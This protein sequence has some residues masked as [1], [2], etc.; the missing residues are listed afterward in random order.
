MLLYCGH[1]VAY[2]LFT[3]I[4]CRSEQYTAVLWEQYGVQPICMYT[5]QCTGMNRILL[6]CGHSVAYNL[7]TCILYRNEQYTAVLWAQCGVQSI[8]FSF[9]QW[10]NENPCSEVKHN[11]FYGRTN[12]AQP[13]KKGGDNGNGHLEG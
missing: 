11:F 1:S 4:L 2:N 6:Y 12:E 10:R 13:K 7:Y 9:Y 8:S 3:C 5:V